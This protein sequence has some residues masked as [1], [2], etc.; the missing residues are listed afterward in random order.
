MDEVGILI[1]FSQNLAK[2]KTF[3][4]TWKKKQAGSDLPMVN[5]QYSLQKERDSLTPVTPVQPG[6]CDL[7]LL[8]RNKTPTYTCDAH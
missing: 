6:S 3:T 2:E 5:S 4:I 8:Q 1:H 7:F